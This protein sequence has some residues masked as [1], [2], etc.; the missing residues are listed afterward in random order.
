MV[1][2]C[3]G[4]VS[5]FSVGFSV[6]CWF[7]IDLDFLDDRGAS[8]AAVF[9]AAIVAATLVGRPLFFNGGVSTSPPVGHCL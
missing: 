5:L 8:T 9:V 2:D 7:L 1:S 4:M 3:I 6:A